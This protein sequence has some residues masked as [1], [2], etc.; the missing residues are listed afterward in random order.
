MSAQP[1]RIERDRPIETI[2][3]LLAAIS[4]VAALLSLAYR[5]VRLDPFAI[6][7]GL[8]A[9]GMGGRHQKLAAWAVGIATVCFV[10]GMVIAV[11]AEKPLF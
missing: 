1:E 3:G 10:L 5:P 8:I 2:A 4:I 11:W 9:A 7:V 6:V